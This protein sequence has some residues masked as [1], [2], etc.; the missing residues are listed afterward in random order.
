MITG[1]LKEML[2]RNAQYAVTYKQPLPLMKMSAVMRDSRA[3]VVVISCSDPRLNPYQIL[4]IDAEL[5]EF[6]CL[7]LQVEGVCLRMYSDDMG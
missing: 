6:L 2:A 1:P 5:R 3:G 4:G 7:P